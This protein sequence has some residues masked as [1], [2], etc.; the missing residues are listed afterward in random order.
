MRGEQLHHSLVLFCECDRTSLPGEVQVRHIATI[1]FD[2]H[3]EERAEL[4]FCPWKL[5]ARRLLAQIVERVRH[6]IN[7]RVSDSSWLAAAI[8]RAARAVSWNE[9][10]EDEIER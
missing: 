5:H 3:A 10:A 1:V 4:P 2:R 9:R 8:G 7:P 6:S